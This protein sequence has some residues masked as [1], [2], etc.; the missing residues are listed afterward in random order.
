MKLESAARDGDLKT[1]TSETPAFLDSLSE[2]IKELTPKSASK[3]SDDAADSDP[4]LLREK[5]IVVKT[6]CEEYDE[7]KAGKILDEL[8]TI[9]WSKATNEMLNA[10]TEHLFVSDFDEAISVIDKFEQA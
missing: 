3:D 1:I 7:I 4:K 2:M 8:K 5:L 10:I 6:A 9:T